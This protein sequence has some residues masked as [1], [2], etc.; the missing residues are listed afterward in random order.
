MRCF[1]GFFFRIF[2]YMNESIGGFNDLSKS[3]LIIGY[4]EGNQCITFGIK[5][6]ALSVFERLSLE[7]GHCPSVC[8]GETN[9]K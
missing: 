2:F 7:E 8:V 9:R 4:R 6:R 3:K 5:I 1:E